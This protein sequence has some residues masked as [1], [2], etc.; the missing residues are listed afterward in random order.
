MLANFYGF[1]YVAIQDTRTDIQ[2]GKC[3]ED[4]LDDWKVDFY[5]FLNYDVLGCFHDVVL[6]EVQFSQLVDKVYNLL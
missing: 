1:A 4:F 6:S 5:L 3:P 2:M